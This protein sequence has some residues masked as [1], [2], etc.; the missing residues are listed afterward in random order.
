MR[1]GIFGQHPLASPATSIVTFVTH[2]AMQAGVRDNHHLW[3]KGVGTEPT[4]ASLLLL[5]PTLGGK[6]KEGKHGER[7]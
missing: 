4:L 1:S 7:G 5:H 2:G 6:E 3:G